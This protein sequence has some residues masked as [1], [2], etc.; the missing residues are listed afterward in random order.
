MAKYPLRQTD[1]EQ[2]RFLLSEAARMGSRVSD[3]D[4]YELCTRFKAHFKVPIHSCAVRRA[5]SG[6]VGKMAQ[7]VPVDVPVF[8]NGHSRSKPERTITRSPRHLAL[9]V[10]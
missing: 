8:D 6:C 5:I 3:S 10:H 7:S 4:I 2:Q 1:P 9:S